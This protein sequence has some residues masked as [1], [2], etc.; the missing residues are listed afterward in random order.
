LYR[1]T[2]SGRFLAL[3]AVRFI[4]MEALK[5][6]NGG[7]TQSAFLIIASGMNASRIEV[8]FPEIDRGFGRT[9]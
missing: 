4:L 5:I 2:R 6:V 1:P 3:E 7:R 8:M 9:I